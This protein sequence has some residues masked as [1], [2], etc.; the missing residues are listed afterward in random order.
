MLDS[1]TDFDMGEPK[2]IDPLRT[3]VIGEDTVADA[4][5]LED[6]VSDLAELTQQPEPDEAPPESKD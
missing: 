6:L 2:K 3:Y 4:R 1:R 5:S